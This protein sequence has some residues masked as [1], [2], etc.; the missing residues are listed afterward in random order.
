MNKN[1][2]RPFDAKA[3]PVEPPEFDAPRW[4]PGRRE[5]VV[6]YCKKTRELI[7]AKHCLF[8]DPL[9]NTT[10][11]YWPI[12]KNYK[13]LPIPQEWIPPKVSMNTNFGLVEYC[14]VLVREAD[15]SGSDSDDDMD[16]D[17]DIV[18]TLT[19]RMV[20]IKVNNLE[21]IGKKNKTENPK[22]ELACMQLLGN[23][24]PNV[25]G[26]IDALED[27][28]NLNIVMPYASDGDLFE[29]LERNGD[30]LDEAVAKRWFIQMLNGIRHLHNHGICHRDLSPENVVLDGDKC[31]IIDMGMALRMPYARCDGSITHI[32][33]GGTHRRW[34]RKQIK[35]GKEPYMSPEIHYK[36]PFDGEAIDV[37]SLGVILFRMVTGLP[38]YRIPN[39]NDERFFLMT[40][41][42]ENYLP[43]PGI[44]FSLLSFWLPFQ[45]IRLSADCIH[46]LS[47]MMTFDSEK[48]ATVSEVWNH[49]WLAEVV[50][51]SLFIKVE[52]DYRCRGQEPPIARRGRQELRAGIVSL[53]NKNFVSITLRSIG[54]TYIIN[55]YK[56]INYI[57][58][59]S[60]FE[61][62]SSRG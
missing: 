18:F 25:M 56:S 21:Q 40:Y 22:H 3:P 34:I 39:S 57:D 12:P 46:L 32:Q 58:L 49:P 52:A 14:F 20:A 53:P 41:S 47:R 16:A 60:M 4:K 13:E 26:V 23:D 51:E 8:R 30:K 35:S 38:S 6:V 33:N 10:G 37:W 15:D 29:L 62:R 59:S 24:H 1:Q 19:R 54:L 44:R 9:E 2:Q 17:D 5:T 50:K 55:Y 48:R 28:K 42:L 31:L 61:T 36:W 7:K 45:G 11:A 27:D 43:L